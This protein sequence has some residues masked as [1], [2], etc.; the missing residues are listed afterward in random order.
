[1]LKKTLKALA[2]L[3]SKKKKERVGS[4]FSTGGNG[5]LKSSIKEQVA[6][7]EKEG[8]AIKSQMKD[9]GYFQDSG[10]KGASQGKWKNRVRANKNSLYKPGQ[11]KATSKTIGGNLPF[12]ARYVIRRIG[13]KPKPF[14]K[15]SVLDVMNKVGYDMIADATAEDVALGFTNTFK[16]A[17]IEG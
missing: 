11:F 15:P 13:L 12:A 6:G 17:K 7:N 5:G 1:M 16:N 14:V 4:I 9:Y 3:I 10:V 2:K 8:F